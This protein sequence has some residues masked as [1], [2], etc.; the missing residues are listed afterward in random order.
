[1]AHRGDSTCSRAFSARARAISFTNSDTDLLL[2][3]GRG[4]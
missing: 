4:T 1:M 3:I 2:Y